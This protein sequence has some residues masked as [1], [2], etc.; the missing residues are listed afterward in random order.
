MGEEPGSAVYRGPGGRGTHRE[1]WEETA[2]YSV[3][4]QMR[5]RNGVGVVLSREPCEQEERS[6]DESQAAYS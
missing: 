4:E 3:V 5:G 2:N 1:S 6:S